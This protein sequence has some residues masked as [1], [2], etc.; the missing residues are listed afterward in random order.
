[1]VYT[2]LQDNIVVKSNQSQNMN[3]RELPRN[4]DLQTET[5]LF[6][7]NL[8]SKEQVIVEDEESSHQHF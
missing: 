6:T 4:R 2:T 1:M 7:Q 8:T 3:I 5:N